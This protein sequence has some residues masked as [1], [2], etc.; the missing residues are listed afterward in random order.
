WGRRGRNAGWELDGEPS[1]ARLVGPDPNV[2]AVVFDDL[3][4]D[5]QP[6]AGAIFFGRKIGLE[7]ARPNLR[8]YS[9]SVVRNI[10]TDHASRRFVA[11]GKLDFALRSHCC[12]RVV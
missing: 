4:N 10:Q 2:A 1:P 7:D 5:R 12:Y 9:R 11:R 3:I 6:Q 8:R